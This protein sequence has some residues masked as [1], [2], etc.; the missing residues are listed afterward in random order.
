[1]TSALA[2]MGYT[3]PDGPSDWFK[4]GCVTQTRS[5]I[6]LWDFA[7]S[8]ERE[9]CSFCISCRAGRMYMKTQ[10]VPLP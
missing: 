1:M 4:N 7:E 9:V 2:G 10:V 6:L 5:M 3:A 8:V